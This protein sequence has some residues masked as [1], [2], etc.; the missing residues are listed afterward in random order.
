MDL[1]ALSLT[2]ILAGCTT[3][4]LTV[5][6]LPLAWWLATTR[7]P[8]RP[9]IEALVTLPLVLPPT[10]LGFY[11][12]LALAPDGLIGAPVLRFFGIRLAFSFPGLL[13]GSALFNMPFAVRPFVA[14]FETVDRR[15]LDAARCLGVSDLAVFFRIA[16]PLARPGI[17]CGAILTFAHAIG[18]F[19]VVLMIG[20]NLPGVTRTLSIAIYDDV[21][22]MNYAVAG[23]TALA[24]L[25]TALVALTVTQRLQPRGT[26]R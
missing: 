12:L 26:L 10:V 24:L 20:G 8:A 11:L 18:E 13:L 9:W 23:R 15:C 1:Q 5:V 3:A 19:G 22:A 14:A 21:Q 16:L 4:L 2:L 25:A 7:H 17:V 6:G